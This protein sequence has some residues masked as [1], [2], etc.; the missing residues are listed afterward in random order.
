[1]RLIFTDTCKLMGH[2]K[3]TNKKKQKKRNQSNHEFSVKTCSDHGL[4]TQEGVRRGCGGG[5]EGAVLMA[6][7]VLTSW[8]QNMKQMI[9]IDFYMFVSQ[10]YKK[11][12]EPSLTHDAYD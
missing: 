7:R 3:K 11:T 6:G 12:V 4:G 1:M 9:F 8:N 2:N 5:A 10:S